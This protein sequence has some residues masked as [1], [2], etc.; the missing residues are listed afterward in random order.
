MLLNKGKNTM[1]PLTRQLLLP[2]L[3]IF[4]VVSLAACGS[5]TSGPSSQVFSGESAVLTN[6]STVQTWGANGYGQ[7]GNGSIND[8]HTPVKLGGHY[9]AVTVGGAHT[10]A[11]KGD[12]VWAWGYNGNGQLGNNSTSNSSTP[13][14]VSGGGAALSNI[15][16]VAAGGRHSLALAGDG[17]VW[18]WGD[19]TYGQLG[20]PS[21]D[22][23][24]GY[25]TTPVSVA[26]TN[27][28]NITKIAAGGDFSLA[29]KDDGTGAGTGTVWAW[30]NNTNGQ[31]GIPNTTTVNNY[32]EPQQVV[33]ADGSALAGIINIAA[34]GS[35]GLAIDKD[36]N[37][38]AWGYNIFGQL[39][40]GT[41]TTQFRAVKVNVITGTAGGMKISAGLDHSLAIINGSVWAWGYNIYGQLGQLGSG[42]TQLH[43]FSPLPVFPT[44]MQITAFGNTVEFILALGNH[45]IARTSDGK[46]WTWGWDAYGQLGDDATTDRSNPMV[47]LGP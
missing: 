4:F 8:S 40:D 45:S 9:T 22:T 11:L 34:G 25:S 18:A 46:Y 44:P 35:H 29:L 36:G 2:I 23:P 10:L 19:N 31:L 20:V 16:A 30:G 1:H 17:T 32:S 6:Y 37:I 39:G 41:T 26:G 33:K 13:V 15:I 38:W 28:A 14:Q 7:L 27:L 12:T 3:A 47:V 42:Q 5:N 43:S 21:T 24:S